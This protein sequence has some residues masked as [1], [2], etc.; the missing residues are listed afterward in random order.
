MAHSMDHRAREV[1]VEDTPDE[2]KME[3]ES[4]RKDRPNLS[5]VFVEAS[6]KTRYIEIF[7]GIRLLAMS[8]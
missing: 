2:D 3:N 7:K 6:Q 5:H 8:S 4:Q 1:T